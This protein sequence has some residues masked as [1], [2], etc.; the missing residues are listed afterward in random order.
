MSEYAGKRSRTAIS[1]EAPATA[2][3]V[4]GK[5]PLVEP[6][7]ETGPGPPAQSSG[8]GRRSIAPSEAKPESARPTIQELFGSRFVA[9][10]ENLLPHPILR[11][12]MSDLGCAGH[13]D[14]VPA[15]DGSPMPPE[16][17]A[18]MEHALGANFSGV[19][20][21]EG[22]Q[23]QAL[24][25]LACTQGTDIHFAPA[26]YDPD[27]RRGQE[28]LGHELTHVMQQAQGRVSAPH[29]AKGAPI[30]DDTDLERE[31]DDFGARAARGEAVHPAG[32]GAAPRPTLDRGAPL[33]LKLED[34][35]TLLFQIVAAEQREAG[36]REAEQRDGMA[37]KNLS[38]AVEDLS[39][40]DKIALRAYAR[41]IP[42]GQAI[43]AKFPALD[44]EAMP[45][46]PFHPLEREPHAAGRQADLDAALR[47]EQAWTP[48]WI[49]DNVIF[50]LSL[51]RTLPGEAAERVKEWLFDA[52][53][54][55]F[56][57]VI[58][59]T[60]G[61]F[62][63]DILWEA[64]DGGNGRKLGTDLLSSRGT[65][66]EGQATPPDGALREDLRNQ[67]ARASDLETIKALFAQR[68]LI[69]SISG[70]WDVAEL[71][72]LY[73]TLE[74][75]PDAHTC[76][77]LSLLEVRGKRGI[78]RGSY[79]K[80][81]ITIE[82]NPANLDKLDHRFG[83]RD[84]GPASSFMTNWGAESIAFQDK[85]RFNE[86]VRHEVGHAIDAGDRYSGQYCIMPAGGH[87][88]FHNNHQE[89]AHDAFAY[90]GGSFSRDPA[91]RDTELLEQLGELL[92]KARGA[93]N[94]R[95][96]AMR[97]LTE[98]IQRTYPAEQPLEPEVKQ[99][100]PKQPGT[101]LLGLFGSRTS[102]QSS[103]RAAPRPT[104]PALTTE[105]ELQLETSAL[106]L[107]SDPAFK[108]LTADMHQEAQPGEAAAVNGRAFVDL[109]QHGH[110]SERTA[111]YDLSAR[112]RQ[113]SDYQFVSPSEWFA[114]A[115]AAYYEPVSESE[116]KGERLKERDPTTWAFIRDEVDR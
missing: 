116:E 40:E 110:G 62:D 65:K 21:H 11:K 48:T 92:H 83:D 73:A 58:T 13:V 53:R 82:Y 28:L 42:N 57:L 36:Q 61:K 96:R 87:W 112:M 77:N 74:E 45:E 68:F 90:S 12:T 107:E 15:S 93:N 113:V 6:L 44:G 102:A 86:V 75:L 22:P 59:A 2:A 17:Q 85:D 108:L 29:Q 25:A 72:K 18:R 39:E 1:H 23:A 79:E 49:I 19:R 5:R 115:Y 46:Q 78:D 114:E 70:T 32:A 105:Q 104:Q 98:H 47:D 71:K 56:D 81:G 16:L 95:D 30:H 76:G 20:I 41:T 54:K 4:P 84:G 67:L 33:Q 94:H 101:G 10:G 8:S 88:K 64:L 103:P 37:M 50:Q 111:S 99:P 69:P 7:P 38:F 34:A 89:L 26:H 55:D 97:H 3:A 60:I 109:S 66:G 27:S 106:A 63:L 51:G 24:G 52:P 43:L 91:F 31:A 35:R 80:Q 100:P 14:V 9:R